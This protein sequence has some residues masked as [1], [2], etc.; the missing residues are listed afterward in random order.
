M[1]LRRA[2]GDLVCRLGILRDESVIERRLIYFTIKLNF[3]LFI[4][5]SD[6]CRTNNP[7]YIIKVKVYL[8]G[9]L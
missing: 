7:I 6:F 5:V 2:E 9:Y 1:C 3:I 4:I 8:Y